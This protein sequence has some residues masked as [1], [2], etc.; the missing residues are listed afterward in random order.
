MLLAFLVENIHVFMDKAKP[1]INKKNLNTIAP[2]E[3]DGKVYDVR[4]LS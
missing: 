1:V 3:K 2:G 4:R